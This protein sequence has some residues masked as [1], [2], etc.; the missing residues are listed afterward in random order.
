MIAVEE[1]AIASLHGIVGAK[2][3]PSH[4]ENVYETFQ[5]RGGK[6]A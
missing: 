6:I 4:F 3:K 5:L 2:K 1:G